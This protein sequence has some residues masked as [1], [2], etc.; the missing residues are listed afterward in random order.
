MKR[1][2]FKYPQ[3]VLAVWVLL[4]AAGTAL[5]IAY[6]WRIYDHVEEVRAT[7]PNP[8]LSLAEDLM[9]RN[10][11]AEAWEQVG[12]ARQHNA[13][14]PR[15]WQVAG[16]LHFRVEQWE[17]ARTAYERAIEL[18]TTH[19][20]AYLNLLWSLIKLQYYRDAANLGRE[21][22][23]F[24]ATHFDDHDP[25]F[26]RYVAEALVRRGDRVEAIP[27]LERA[28]DGYGNDFYLMQNLAQAYRLAGRLEESRA[29]QAR[30]AEERARAGPGTV[31]A[32][33]EGAAP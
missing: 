30:I 11:V 9:N 31:P 1:R 33:A 24:F 21:F 27:Y 25:I 20:G 16:D 18:G 19:K 5:S 22:M 32:P 12:I 6:N 8:A 28:L 17:E 23:R 10:R 26:P 2:R 7:D 4:L 3:L 13:E 14:H 29:M 15:V